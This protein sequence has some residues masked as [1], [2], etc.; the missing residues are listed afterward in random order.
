MSSTVAFLFMFPSENCISRFSQP[1][2]SL[3]DCYV[4]TLWEI[5]FE[6]LHNASDILICELVRLKRQIQNHIL[7]FPPAR[8]C[9]E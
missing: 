6:T 2:I 1:D 3:R 5:H 4:K 7:C 9:K 8:I